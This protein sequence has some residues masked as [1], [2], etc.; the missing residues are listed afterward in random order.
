MF[1]IRIGKAY[2]M[3][4]KMVHDAMKALKAT[5]GPRYNNPNRTLKQKHSRIVRTGTSSLGSIW[6]KYLDRNIP[7]SR[8]MA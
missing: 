3:L 8:A 4:R 2:E 6:L 1:R 7:L 5:V